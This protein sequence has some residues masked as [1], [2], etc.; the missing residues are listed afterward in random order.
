MRR[1]IQGRWLKPAALKP[2]MPLLE[3]GQIIRDTY[4]VERFLGQ[5][6]FAEVYRVK[7]RFLGRQA[8]KVFKREGMTIQ[9][10]EEMLGEAIMLSRLGHP[11]IVRVFDANVLKTDR[12]LCGFFTMENV[13]GGSLEKFWHSFGPQF[14]P[15]ETTVDLIKQ[16]CRGLAIAHGQ[17]PPVI[18]R[19]I[20]PQ[21]ILVG[22]EPEGLRARLSDFGL[23]KKVNPLT[24]LATA[25]GTPHF[26]PPEAFSD[27]K[28][29]SCA[30]DVW[31]IG[32]TLYLLL[33]DQLPFKLPSDLGWV[34]AKSFKQ[35]ITPPS[36]I[37]PDVDKSLDYVITRALD[38]NPRARIQTAPELL[39]SLGRWKPV[40]DRPKSEI[41]GTNS[42]MSKTALGIKH[43][44]PDQG[45]AEN[46]ARQAIL[47]KKQG[48]LADAADLMEEAFNKWPSLRAKYANQV[49]LWR[50]GISM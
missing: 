9:E 37:N 16:V 18:H 11:N 1:S 41:N 12:G 3:E 36:D 43:S 27:T 42:E 47:I 19:D 25:A 35:P 45:E 39:D 5:G 23:A 49:R 26:K 33:T 44:C 50:C 21:N 20:K 8:M 40:S 30:G 13:P 46:M 32:T 38:I 14:V 34:D 2:T 31:A 4:E 6:A 28:G 29:D 17:S 10:I 24:L 7:H 48:K 15:V 22:Y